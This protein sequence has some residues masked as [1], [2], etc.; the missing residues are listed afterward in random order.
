[1][2][3]YYCVFWVRLNRFTVRIMSPEQWTLR[4]QLGTLRD[5]GKKSGSVPDV[6]GPLATKE[7]RVTYCGGIDTSD[8]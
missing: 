3:Q 2:V 8:I 1:M 5:N 7:T 6:P 4:K